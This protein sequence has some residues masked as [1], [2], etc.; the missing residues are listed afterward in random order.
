MVDTATPAVSAALVEVTPSEVTSVAARTTINA[1]A[2]GELLS[3]SIASLLTETS[4]S[5]TDLAAIV[6]GVG[7]GPYTGLRVGLVTATAMAQALGIPTYGVCS[8]DGLGAAAA[9][10]GTV[11]VA[12]DARRREVYWRVYDAGRPITDPAVDRPADLVPRLA[13]WGVTTA[14]GEGAQ[15]YAETLGLPVADSPRYP[16]PVTLARLAAERVR[17]GAPSEP[18]TPLYLRRPDATLPGARKPV[19]Q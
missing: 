1:R 14:V 13:E 16:D 5:V 4:V 9:D 15:R 17:A 18:L 3:P 12:T 11:L 8:L 2:H 6:A 19:L 10:S 7:P